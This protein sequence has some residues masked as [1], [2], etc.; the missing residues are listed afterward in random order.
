[1]I[2]RLEAK[3][4]SLFSIGWVDTKETTREKKGSLGN[5]K[6][7]SWPETAGPQLILNGKT[8]KTPYCFFNHILWQAAGTV[9]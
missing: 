4:Q 2:G 9:S 6:Q 7:L 3:K 5:K 1:M 8:M